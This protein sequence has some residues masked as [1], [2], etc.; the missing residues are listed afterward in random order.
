MRPQTVEISTSSI[1][2]TLAILIA[3][4]VAWQLRFVFILILASIILMTAFAQ[5][6]DFLQG[7]GFNRLGAAVTAYVL[8]VIFWGLLIFLVLPPLIVQLRE[9]IVD[10][11]SYLAKISEIYGGSFVPGI[12]NKQVFTVGANYLATGLDSVMRVIFTTITGLFNL[13]TIA[14]LSFYLLLERDRIKRNLY[15]II[16]VLPKE[17]VTNLV[18]KVDLQLGHWVRGEIALMFIVGLATYI[19]LSLLKVPYALP[20]AVMTG[21]LE[22]IPNIGPILSGFIAT[23]VT[24]ASGNP[25]SA[26]GVVT[27]YVIVQQL[28]NNILVPKIMQAAVGLNPLVAILSFVVG[29]TLFGL[30]GALIAVPTAA[31]L[32]VVVLDLYDFATRK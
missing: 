13:I 15:R 30:P 25:V 2:K 16:P 28:E 10:S 4:V 22:F 23:L 14:V 26:V 27:L 29:A 5:I 11:P 21:V 3:L 18:H 7:K 8:A 6:S 32:Q 24:V 9:F 12:E 19:G 17:R 31:M 1:I 20:L